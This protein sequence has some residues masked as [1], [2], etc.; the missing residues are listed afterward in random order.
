MYVRHCTYCSVENLSLVNDL[1]SKIRVSRFENACQPE[2]KIHKIASGFSVD[3]AT[4]H[5]ELVLQLNTTILVQG[6]QLH[7]HYDTFVIESRSHFRS[8]DNYQKIKV[9]LPEIKPHQTRLRQRCS[10]LAIFRIS[11][12]GFMVVCFW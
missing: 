7:C 8:I 6:I 10:T 3:E 9:P 1:S 4:D 12:Q 2:K 5:P 11:S